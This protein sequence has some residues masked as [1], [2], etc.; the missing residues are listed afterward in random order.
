MPENNQIESN[1]AE[2]KSWEEKLPLN[3]LLIIF[4]LIWVGT[5][6]PLVETDADKYLSV[7]RG[8][9]TDEGLYTAQIRNFI[10]H[11]EFDILESDTFIKTPLFSFWLGL[12]MALLG[13]YWV[14]GRLTVL[15]SFLVLMLF[16]L[17]NTAFKQLMLFLIPVVFFR[18]AIHQ[19]AHISL[20]E[21]LSIGLIVLGIYAFF[22][23]LEGEKGDWQALILAQ[24]FP[25]LAFLMKF[26]FAYILFLLPGWAILWWLGKPRDRFRQRTILRLFAVT[27]I[28]IL[29]FYIAWYL[30]FKEEMNYLLGKQSFRMRLGEGWYDL[31]DFIVNYI[32]LKEPNIWHT[33]VWL[34]ALPVGLILLPFSKSRSYKLLYLAGLSWCV[35]ESHKLL[36]EYLPTRYLLSTYFAMGFTVCVVL[37]ELFW[38]KIVKWQ[39]VKYIFQVLAIG[40]LLFLAYQN[41]RHQYWVYNRRAYNVRTVNA[42][43]AQFDFK[44]RPIIGSWAS[45]LAWNSKAITFPVWDKKL[46]YKAPIRTYNPAIV[47]TEPDEEDSNQAYYNNGVNLNE[48]TD[49]LKTFTIAHWNVQ[50][51]WISEKGNSKTGGS[52]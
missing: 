36:M 52:R 30:P 23:Y 42:Y 33:K 39:G 15:I 17:R 20:S 7:S 5:E 47:V 11:G 19:F 13:T 25:Y 18:Y 2:F 48:V 34:V 4:L 38:G 41:A 3:W 40:T 49:S 35:L 6:L 32:F 22:K 9:F 29:L 46:H 45:S 26:Q 43:L 10:N 44:D 14:V 1:K 24:L 28:Q 8:P 50:V 12:P 51:R 37:Q 21:M 31:I 27:A 16:T